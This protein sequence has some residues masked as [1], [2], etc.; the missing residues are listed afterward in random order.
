MNF[1]GLPP[2]TVQGSTSFT[3]LDSAATTAPSPI[4]T[5]L[6]T[7][8]RVA[9]QTQ[10]PIF[11]GPVV[12]SNV[13]D[14]ILCEPVRRYTSLPIHVFFPMTTSLW[15][16]IKENSPKLDFSFMV[17]F[18]GAMIVEVLSIEQLQS[19]FAPNSFSIA[20]RYFL[21]KK[22]FHLNIVIFIIAQTLD[23]IL[24]AMLNGVVCT[25][26]ISFILFAEYKSFYN[27]SFILFVFL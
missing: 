1:A 22:K 20:T 27:L 14:S 17:K 11:I 9:T 3:T 16:I 13:F 2:T 12:S 21:I 7:V 25:G 6:P 19:I 10:L 18:Q 4:V 23:F 26:L 5:P 24:Y 8:E 15:H